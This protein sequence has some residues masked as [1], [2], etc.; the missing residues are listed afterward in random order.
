MPHFLRQRCFGFRLRYGLYHNGLHLHA[1]A[2]TDPHLL[3]PLHHMA[4]DELSGGSV[5]LFKV[6]G[7]NEW[8]L[9]HF[10]WV[11][12]L[13]PGVESFHARSWLLVCLPDSV[14]GGRTVF[15]NGSA[16]AGP[17][18]DEHHVIRP[19]PK[20]EAMWINPECQDHL[21]V[22]VCGIAAEFAKGHRLA[23]RSIMYNAQ[24]ESCSLSKNQ[25]I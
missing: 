22:A 23:G 7:Y 15:M 4:A 8:H 6:P 1:L 10:R 5:G 17:E 25:Y 21:L 18:R 11:A 14:K 12:A 13:S 2:R 19:A 24:R 9:G 16:G 3:L 20:I